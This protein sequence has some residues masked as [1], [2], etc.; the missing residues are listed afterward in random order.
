MSKITILKPELMNITTASGETFVGGC[1][2]W[3]DDEWQKRAGCGPV[4][5]A[6][7]YWYSMRK[8]DITPDYTQ[9]ILEMFDFVTPGMRG[10]NTSAMFV[11]G[12]L[13]FV[14]K[15]NMQVK[16]CVLEVPT[17]KSTRPKKSEL[18]EFVFNALSMDSPVAF[19]NLSNGTVEALENW[20][21]VTIIAFDPKTMLVDIADHGKVITIDI[22]EWKKTSLFGGALV[23]FI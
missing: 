18:S 9:L 11:D 1:Q 19:L 3:Y 13:G 4:T 5:A 16:P 14:A 23:Y 6:N 15:H 8:N 20:H 22:F 21:W 12:F 10:V 17:K 7:I 2:E